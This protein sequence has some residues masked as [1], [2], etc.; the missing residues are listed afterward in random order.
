[1]GGSILKNN[2]S[3]ILQSHEL[4]TLI[5]KK[6][7]RML[8]EIHHEDFTKRK[9]EIDQLLMKMI[10]EYENS[11]KSNE[12]SVDTQCDNE[13]DENDDNEDDDDEEEDVNDV[14]MT[15]VKNKKI[16]NENNHDDSMSESD[17]NTDTKDEKLARKL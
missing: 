15:D 17:E 14:E 10:S 6:V 2:I 11:K 8:E 3:D 1:M 16:K 7:R 5:S 9:L 4:S 12:S 13:D